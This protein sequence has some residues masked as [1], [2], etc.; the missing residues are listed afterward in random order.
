MRSLPPLTDGKRCKEALITVVARETIKVNG[1]KYDTFKLIPD[2]K[3]IGGVFEKSKDAK[4]EIWCTADHRHI[5]VLLK[6]KVFVG[7]FKA[8]LEN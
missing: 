2:F 5:P 6:S 3:D 4:V 8:E 7:S 1:K